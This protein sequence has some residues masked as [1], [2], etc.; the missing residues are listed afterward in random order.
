MLNGVKICD[1]Q[2]FVYLSCCGGDGASEHFKRIA[3][4]ED[5][6]SAFDISDQIIP[7]AVYIGENDIT[8]LFRTRSDINKIIA[9]K[10]CAVR[11]GKT[12]CRKFDAA[13]FQQPFHS[14]NIG[15]I[16]VQIHDIVV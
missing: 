6:F 9:A 16:A 11:K 13:L 4:H 12:V 1:L 7:I 10:I 3:R 2:S 5:D 15:I 14:G 8:V